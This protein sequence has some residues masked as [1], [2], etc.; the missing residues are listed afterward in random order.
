MVLTNF[1]IIKYIFINYKET[2]KKAGSPLEPETVICTSTCCVRDQLPTGSSHR[3][4]T[5][6]DMKY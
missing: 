1:I 6:D 5:F 3:C 2:N 4:N